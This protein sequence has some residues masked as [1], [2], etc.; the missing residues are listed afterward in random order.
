MTGDYNSTT[1][2]MMIHGATFLVEVVTG[3]DRV[4]LDVY[5]PFG[6]VL[7]YYYLVAA[8]APM[9]VAIGARHQANGPYL[10]WQSGA[11][12]SLMKIIYWWLFST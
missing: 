11:W 4:V 5:E 2:M 6:Y 1:M 7:A 10:Y 8:A 9:G 3:N 12:S